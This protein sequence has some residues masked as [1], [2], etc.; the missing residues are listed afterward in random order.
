M[1]AA[2]EQVFSAPAARE[3]KIELRQLVLEH[4][5]PAKV[6]E[7]FSGLSEMWEG[8][9]QLADDYTGCDIAPLKLDEPMARM[10][11]DNQLA[12]RALDLQRF[13]V[14]DFDAFGSPWNCALILATLRKWKPGEQG[15]VVLTDGSSLKIRYGELPHAMANLIG[16]SPKCSAK[17]AIAANMQQL[18]LQGFA[19]RAGVTIT[20]LWRFEGNGSGKGGQMMMYS[21]TCFEGN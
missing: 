11:C 13:N 4:V 9:W 6:F 12:L 3:K 17:T 7:A 18:A 14:F 19:R 5:R 10:C 15:A 8:A 16:C 2:T 1:A 20:N 21:A